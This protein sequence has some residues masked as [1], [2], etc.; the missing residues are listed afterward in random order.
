[1]GKY[2]TGV[3]RRLVLISVLCFLST[4]CSLS[5]TTISSA[6]DPNALCVLNVVAEGNVFSIMVNQP[7][8][9]SIAVPLP[10]A[11][12]VSAPILCSDVESAGLA[13]ANQTNT[14]VNV[15]VQILAKD[16]TLICSKGPVVVAVN[17]GRG[18]TFSD[19]Q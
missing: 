10:I 6:D 8:G 13:V 4:L 5:I 11:K 16:G 15:A 18:F 17:G 9:F 2:V 3:Y 12:D 7:Q 1:M 19:C 14:N